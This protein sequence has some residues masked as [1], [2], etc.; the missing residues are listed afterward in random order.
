MDP[1]KEF[2]SYV[3][4]GNNEKIAALKKAYAI[5]WRGHRP[6]SE[7]I[8]QVREEIPSFPELDLLLS[9]LTKSKRGILR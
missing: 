3:K 9:F 7:G 2:I 1:N 6:F 5:L 4:L 8:R